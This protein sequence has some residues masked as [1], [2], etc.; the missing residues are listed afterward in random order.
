MQEIVSSEADNGHFLAR[1]PKRVVKI[2]LHA[3]ASNRSL[4]SGW[5][6]PFLDGANLQ[7][8]SSPVS[9]ISVP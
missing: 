9:A 2:E 3:Q 4:R 7:P 5:I 8:A 1:R 6:G